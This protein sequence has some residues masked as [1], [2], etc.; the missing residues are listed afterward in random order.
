MKNLLFT[1]AFLVFATISAFANNGGR[2]ADNLELRVETNTKSA[3]VF[4]VKSTSNM[5]ANLVI[6]SSE[7]NIVFA[8]SMLK[9]NAGVNMQVIDVMELPAG[10]Y[11]I[12]LSVN[13]E[14]IAQHF[15]IK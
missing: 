7:Q 5:S 1:I 4:Q 12:S 2:L 11:I 9:L 13:G 15:I 6:K 10:D 8:D 14:E 3:L